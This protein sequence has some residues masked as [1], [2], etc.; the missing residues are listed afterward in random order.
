M[1]GATTG[2]L[3]LQPARWAA[4]LARAIPLKGATAVRVSSCGGGAG[5]AG[6][7][8]ATSDCVTDAQT[9]SASM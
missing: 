6:W 4:R 1:N 9:A 8:R 3:V 2:L 5:V 7:V